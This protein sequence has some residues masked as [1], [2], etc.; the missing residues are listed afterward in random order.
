MCDSLVAGIKKPYRK[1]VCGEDEKFTDRMIA[2]VSRD[3]GLQVRAMEIE[4]A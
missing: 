4:R 3:D 1:S 2:Q